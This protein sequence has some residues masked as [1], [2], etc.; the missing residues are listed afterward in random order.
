MHG[1]ALYL[2]AVHPKIDFMTAENITSII[3]LYFFIAVVAS[4]FVAFRLEKRLKARL[5][6]TQP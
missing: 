1:M 6:D 2:E 5:P 3:Y 4:I